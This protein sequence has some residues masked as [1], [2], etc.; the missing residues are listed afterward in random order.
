[1]QWIVFK[2]NPLTDKVVYTIN[3]IENVQ[4]L[5]ETEFIIFIKKNF[6]INDLGKFYEL[7]NSHIVLHLEN[8]D[9]TVMK[10]FDSYH[11][12]LEKSI[13]LK[14][15]QKLEIKKDEKVKTIQNTMKNYISRLSWN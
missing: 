12:L 14:D 6:I 3:N 7:L 4:T 5:K 13:T 15:L 11:N 10:E 2:K 8:G 9:L 1:M